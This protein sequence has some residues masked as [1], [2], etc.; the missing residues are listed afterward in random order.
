MAV[1]ERFNYTKKYMTKNDTVRY[2]DVLD[3]IISNYNNTVHSSIKHTP[4]EVFSE[5]E[6]PMQQ[7]L[8]LKK[9]DKRKFKI[10]DSVRA[11]KVR[12]TLTSVVSFQHSL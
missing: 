3:D 8:D 12:K 4:A 10:G 11:I 1:V 7:G 5:K 6:Y 9:T 2:V